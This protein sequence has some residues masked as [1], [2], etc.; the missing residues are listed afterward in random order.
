MF[1]KLDTRGRPGT[2]WRDLKLRHLKVDNLDKLL[3]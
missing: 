1:G 3:F 2:S